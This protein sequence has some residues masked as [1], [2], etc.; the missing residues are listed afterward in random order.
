ME[1][2]RHAVHHAPYRFSESSR[3]HLISTDLWEAI[4]GERL[5]PA[6]IC[7]IVNISVPMDS[8]MATPN[9]Q[10]FHCVLMARDRNGSRILQRKLEEGSQEERNLIFNGLEPELKALISDPC[11]NFVIQKMCDVLDKRQQQVLLRTLLSDV[12]GIVEVIDSRVSTNGSRFHDGELSGSIL[13]LFFPHNFVPCCNLRVMHTCL[14]TGI[15]RVKT[16]GCM[17]SIYGNVTFVWI[18]SK[19][20][21]HFFRKRI[22]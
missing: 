7:D 15:A 5:T 2:P 12:Q 14:L 18:F 16:C 1:S 20:L 13:R 22:F 8:P 21:L 17:A 19:K 4:T 3:V 6:R 11:A 10:S 9:Q